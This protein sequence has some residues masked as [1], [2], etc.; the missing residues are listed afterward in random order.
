MGHK[1]KNEGE[2]SFY[3]AWAFIPRYHFLEIGNLKLVWW[4]W[5]D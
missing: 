4:I 3:K 1:E 5:S 2:E